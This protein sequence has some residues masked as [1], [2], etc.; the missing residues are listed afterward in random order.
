MGVDIMQW[1]VYSK[2]N[3]YNRRNLSAEFLTYSPDPV[4]LPARKNIF[5]R[6]NNNF[7]QL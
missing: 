3:K 6:D 7:Y 4:P 5:L 1:R 2:N